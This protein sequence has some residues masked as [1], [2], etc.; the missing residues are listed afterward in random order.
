[1]SLPQ[2]AYLTEA[3]YLAAEQDAA[4]R[5]EYVD[6]HIYAM[7]GASKSHGRIAGNIFYRLRATP[8]ASAC[9]IVQNDLKVRIREPSVY[10]YPDV[11]VACDPDDADPYYTETPCFI[12]EVL[13]PG[14]A[15][16]DRRE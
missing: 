2:V 5:H 10:Y 13:S 11:V 7:G 9:L 4:V 6:G 15:S 16:M 8:Q 3:E 1:M 14:T 12:A